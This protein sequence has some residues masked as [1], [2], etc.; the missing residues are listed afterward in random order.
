[1][2]TKPHGMILIKVKEK[3]HHLE[4]TQQMICSKKIKSK[5]KDILLVLEDK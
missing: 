1:M 5:E 4:L 2:D 3:F